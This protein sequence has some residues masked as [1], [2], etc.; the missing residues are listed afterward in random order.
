MA[1]W[2]LFCTWDQAMS[3]S[4]PGWKVSSSREPP[5][6]S[7]VATVRTWVGPAVPLHWHG[8]DDFGL[9]TASVAAPRSTFDPT[10]KD[11]SAIPIE[12]R[13]AEEVLSLSGTRVAPDGVGALHPAFDVT[14][15]ELIRAIVTE[16]GP[17]EPVDE[18]TVGKFLA[19]GVA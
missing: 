11:G 14:P 3:G 19:K 8:H 7:L 1:S 2:S 12:E 9:A 16:D 15:H 6:E 5:A 13:P 10:A 18:E 17:I 4:V